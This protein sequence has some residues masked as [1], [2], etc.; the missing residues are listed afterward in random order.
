MIGIRGIAM[1]RDQLLRQKR[2]YDEAVKEVMRKYKDPAGVKYDLHHESGSPAGFI[3]YMPK[4]DTVFI[5]AGGTHAEFAGGILKS[6]RDV[7]N[8]ILDD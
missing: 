2:E 4:S 1:G 3:E 8:K 6:L 7:L 5:H